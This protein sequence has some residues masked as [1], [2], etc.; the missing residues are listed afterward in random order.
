ML[1]R[2]KRRYLALQLETEGATSE[3]AFIEAIWAS[4]TQLFGEYGASFS[5][6]ALIRYDCESK[7]AVIRVN[8]EAF[9][10]LR[11]TLATIT[12]IGD[13]PAAVHVIAVSGTIKALLAN[14]RLKNIS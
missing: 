12:S 14:K 6:L 5:N 13:K 7:Q 4:F 10:N 1:K 3:Q 9:N 8:L 2:L 11:A